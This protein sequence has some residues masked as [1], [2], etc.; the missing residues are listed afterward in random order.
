MEKAEV[1]TIETVKRSVVARSA[2]KKDRMNRWSTVD[3]K[4]CD[5]ILYDIVMVDR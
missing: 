5:T 2:G 4:G 3:F 1:K